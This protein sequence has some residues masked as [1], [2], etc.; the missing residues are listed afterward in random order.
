MDHR[1]EQQHRTPI[2]NVA[3]QTSTHPS[4]AAHVPNDQSNTATQPKMYTWENQ[5]HR[6]P[7][8]QRWQH[9]LSKKK[10][11]QRQ[12]LKERP[13]PPYTGRSSCRRNNCRRRDLEERQQPRNREGLRVSYRGGRVLRW[14]GETNLVVPPSPISTSEYQ[15]LDL[16]K[17]SWLERLFS[18]ERG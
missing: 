14:C 16:G 15:G 1:S 10:R 7:T 9:K 5:P 11:R 18:L 12:D 13:Q 8:T 4:I 2:E 6:L 3:Q 17:K